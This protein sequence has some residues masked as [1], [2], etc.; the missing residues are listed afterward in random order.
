MW[1]FSIKMLHMGCNNWEKRMFFG[2]GHLTEGLE[3]ITQ[4]NSFPLSGDPWMH[5][6]ET[7]QFLKKMFTKKVGRRWCGNKIPLTRRSYM[8]NVLWNYTITNCDCNLQENRAI[9][10]Y[11]FQ[12]LGSLLPKIYKWKQSS[13]DFLNFQI[14]FVKMLKVTN[15]MTLWT[16]SK[17]EYLISH[18]RK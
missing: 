14:E 2:E 5:C 8:R 1:C 9:I 11:Y 4:T 12:F 7:I 10:N 6:N 13:F 16:L 17:F 3:R 18:C 15:H